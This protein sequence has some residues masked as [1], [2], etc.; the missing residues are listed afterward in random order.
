M[1]Y[2]EAEIKVIEIKSDVVL[3]ASAFDTE[4]DCITDV[5]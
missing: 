3:T 5:E 4:E 1:K 2:T